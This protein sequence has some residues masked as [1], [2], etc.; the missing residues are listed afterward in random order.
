M[1]R[2]RDKGRRGWEWWLNAHEYVQ[3]SI[4]FLT[5]YKLDRAGSTLLN[6]PS[7]KAVT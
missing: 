7:V 6:Q 3:S 1:Y 2:H 5:Q 4:S